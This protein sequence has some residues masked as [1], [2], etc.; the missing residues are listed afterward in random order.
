MLFLGFR[1]HADS[2]SELADKWETSNTNWQTTNAILASFTLGWP[3]LW[4][5]FSRH[6]QLRTLHQGIELRTLHQGIAE[7]SKKPAC[8]HGDPPI[9][10]FVQDP[11]PER[12]YP[13]V[14]VNA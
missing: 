4:C 11:L 9:S 13:G 6:S 8:A 2:V 14:V 5:A 3:I 12:T 10:P 7:P 1:H